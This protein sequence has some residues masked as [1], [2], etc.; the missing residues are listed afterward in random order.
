MEA[1]QALHSD[2]PTPAI[3]PAPLRGPAMGPAQLWRDGWW[4]LAALARGT[5]AGRSRKG[6]GGQAS[7]IN[8]NPR[9]HGTI[10]HADWPAGPAITHSGRW[11]RLAGP[12]L[13]LPWA[14][15]GSDGLL[16]PAEGCGRVRS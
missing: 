4:L 8:T 6:R 9:R 2:R 7:S 1:L 13:D 12:A 16:G 14:E 15:A 11:P 3:A 5:G 10:P